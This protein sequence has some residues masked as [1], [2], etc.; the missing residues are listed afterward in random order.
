MTLRNVTTFFFIFWSRL[1]RDPTIIYV[2]T[3][4]KYHY[5]CIPCES[6]ET[7]T[8]FT[9]LSVGKIVLDMCCANEVDPTSYL[10]RSSDGGVQ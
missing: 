8:N 1:R 9:M 6:F 3:Y 7:I 5:L 4:R 10:Q 2:C